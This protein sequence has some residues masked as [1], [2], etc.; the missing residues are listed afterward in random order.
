MLERMGFEARLSSNSGSA[1]ELVRQEPFDLILT[2]IVMPEREG[3]ELIRDIR[4]LN[5]RIPIIAISGGGRNRP[6]DY[7]KLARALGADATIAKPF[8]S[9]QLS[10]EIEKVLPPST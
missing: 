10:Q 4:R 6:D 2:D 1:I 9:A 5:L 8:T 3:L 7:L